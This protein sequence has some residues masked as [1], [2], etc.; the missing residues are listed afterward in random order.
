MADVSAARSARRGVAFFDECLA[1]GLSQARLDGLTRRRSSTGN[2]CPVAGRC[3]GHTRRGASRTA[4]RSRPDPAPVTTIAWRYLAHRRRVPRRVFGPRWS[5]SALPP[6]SS[7]ER[8]R[9]TSNGGGRP[10]TEPRACRPSEPA[11]SRAAPRRLFD[12]LGP[13]YGPY[14][15]SRR[16][17]RSCCHVIDELVHH[18]AEIAPVARPSTELG[19]SPDGRCPSC[20]APR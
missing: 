1:A 11:S 20:R 16:S 14:G 4:H 12:P 6:T 19:P 9:S 15:D 7:I 10:A 13:S 2:R 5:S 8:S 18:A 3:T 17:S